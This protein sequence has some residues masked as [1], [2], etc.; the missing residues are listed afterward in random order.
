[1]V[2]FVDA[3]AISIRVR[4]ASGVGKFWNYLVSTVPEGLAFLDR[5]I[6]RVALELRK[7]V[8][9]KF[10]IK[11]FLFY[12]AFPIAQVFPV[13][14]PQDRI[15]LHRPPVPHRSYV[16]NMEARAIAWV[17]SRKSMSAGVVVPDTSSSSTSTACTTRK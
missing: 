15:P 8:A 11:A 1:M 4:A 12:S 5:T 14:P 9:L 16:A 10:Q 6:L 3:T 2:G 7:S 13:A 17:N